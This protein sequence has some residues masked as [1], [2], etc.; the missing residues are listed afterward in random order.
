MSQDFVKVPKQFMEVRV[1][2]PDTMGK[3]NEDTES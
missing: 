2:L 3:P 1:G